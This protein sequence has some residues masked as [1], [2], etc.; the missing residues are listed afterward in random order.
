MSPC[1]V[2]DGFRPCHVSFY[3][4]YLILATARQLSALAEARGI[5]GRRARFSIPTFFFLPPIMSASA[6]SH[7][8]TFSRRLA[9]YSSCTPLN[10]RSSLPQPPCYGLNDMPPQGIPAIVSSRRLSM[11][12][13]VRLGTCDCL[14]AS[15]GYG[16]D[17]GGRAPRYRHAVQRAVVGTGCT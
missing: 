7:H 11:S 1:F 2:F 8:R 4:S 15:Q 16:E 17:H 3:S 14:D 13:G 10:I 12:P 9:L 6:S 5:K